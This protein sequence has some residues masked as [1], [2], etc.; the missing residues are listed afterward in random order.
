M[1]MY[2]SG[3]VS[4]QK[5]N[6]QLFLIKLVPIRP[7]NEKNMKYFRQRKKEQRMRI[8]TISTMAQVFQS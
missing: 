2:L 1:Y 7:A 6:A 8:E 3:P 4:F 5:N